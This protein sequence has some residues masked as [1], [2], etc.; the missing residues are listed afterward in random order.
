[1]KLLRLIFAAL[2]AAA[3]GVMLSVAY[4]GSPIAFITFV[5]LAISAQA[6]AASVGKCDPQ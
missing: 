1:M 4:D 6:L 3:A 2:V 5:L